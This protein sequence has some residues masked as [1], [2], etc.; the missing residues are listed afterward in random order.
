MELDSTTSCQSVVLSSREIWRREFTTRTR[1]Q[2]LW[3]VQ[4][5]TMFTWKTHIDSWSPTCQCS[6]PTQSTAD[7]NLWVNWRGLSWS[8]VPAQSSGFTNPIVRS[9]PEILPDRDDGW[10]D[11]R[12]ERQRR[13][14]HIQQ[15][16]LHCPCEEGQVRFGG[17]PFIEGVI[18]K[19]GRF[20]R[21]S[22]IWVKSTITGCFGS[23]VLMWTVPR[24]T[25]CRVHD[26][27]SDFEE[28]TYIGRKRMIV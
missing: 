6:T 9:L 10:K 3:I 18:K 20:C 8:C 5:Q 2:L 17:W 14:S 11:R 28:A 25:A 13:R 12:T 21:W 23:K 27:K 7:E 4:V 22:K 24:H 1:A 19:L 15:L 26:H 16:D